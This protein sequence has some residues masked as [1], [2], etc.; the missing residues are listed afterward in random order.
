[1]KTAQ[2]RV[3]YR[4]LTVILSAIL[5]VASLSATGCS[6]HSLIPNGNNAN[7]T[8]PST[9]DPDNG[10]STNQNGTAGNISVN[11]PIDKP[12]LPTYYNLLTGLGSET[13][14]SA[15]RPVAV[16]IGNVESALPQYGLGQAEILI[17]APIEDGSTRLMMISNSYTQ[18]AQIGPVR[19]TRPYLLSMADAFGAVSVYA[20]T[21][22]VNSSSVYPQ[23][24]TLDYVTQN[25]NTV[26]YRNTSLFA[27]HNLFTSGTRLLGAMENFEKTGAKVPYQ[28]VPYGTAAR[29]SG[30]MASGV[31]IPYST[32]QVVQ[33][34]YDANASVYLRSQ[35][36]NDHVAGETGEQ[37]SF[38]NLLLLVCES[39]I[40]NKVTGT[41]LDLDVNSGG[42]GYYLSAGGYTEILW[43][44][45]AE[46]EIVLTDTEGST[47]SLNRG[48]TYIGLID[49]V[50][51]SSVLIVK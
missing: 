33:F 45:N 9:Q 34:V 1:M 43:S 49:L 12:A 26:F 48:K 3:S 15:T 18:M 24:A 30:G 46:G 2:N 21:S 29:P 36:G 6:F 41:E 13:D 39:S 38:T 35:N 8:S 20:G 28:Y 47:L 51:S 5:V 19:S 25:L 16:C 31:V 42:R 7:T 27:P 23:Y 40:T 22:D 14:M 4:C 32:G 11:K 17:E 10:P 37:L 44:R 50:S